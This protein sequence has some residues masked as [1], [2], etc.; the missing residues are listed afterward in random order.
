MHTGNVMC[1]PHSVQLKYLRQAD[2]LDGFR[3]SIGLP[4]LRGRG[5]A[6]AVE[7]DCVPF[8]YC[9][10]KHLVPSPKDWGPHIDITGAHSASTA[11]AA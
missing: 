6:H 9:F 1:D 7:D 4:S 10:S 5:Y 8:M 3:L 11:S 2:I